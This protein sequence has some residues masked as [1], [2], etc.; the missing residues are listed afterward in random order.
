[1]KRIVYILP[2]YTESHTKQKSYAEVAKLFEEKGFTVVQ[3]E[4]DWALESPAQFKDYAS[5]FLSQF[6]KKKGVKTYILGFSYGATIAFLTANKTRP[7]E[8]ILCSLSP[9]FIED[10]NNLEPRWLKYWKDNFKDSDYSFKEYADKI[11]TKTQ[12]VAGGAEHRSV[13]KRARNARK[14]LK[15]SVLRISEGAKHNIGQKEYLDT[16]KRLVAALD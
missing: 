6:K 15:N 14:V 7:T 16:L 2:G 1:M 10:Q 11:N 5:Q 12:I 13:L 8:L 3:V 9:Y 4:I